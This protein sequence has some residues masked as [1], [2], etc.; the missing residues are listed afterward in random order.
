MYV[1]YCS[2]SDGEVESAGGASD[3]E[4][5]QHSEHDR[6]RDW[7]DLLHRCLL[8]HHLWIDQNKTKT[9]LP[10]PTAAPTLL[11]GNCTAVTTSQEGVV[12]HPSALK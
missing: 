6:S 9:N 4:R 1:C 12:F 8:H 10:K 2:H 7:L 5:E 3:G 11:H